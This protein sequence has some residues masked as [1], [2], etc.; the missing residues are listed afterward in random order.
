[1]LVVPVTRRLPGAPG[2]PG[3]GPGPPPPEQEK[4]EAEKAEGSTASLGTVSVTAQ[5]RTENLQ[6]VPISMLVLG[7]QQLEEMNVT[8][9]D[10]YAKLLPSVSLDRGEGGGSV[11]YMRGVA[12]GENSN[13]S[14][15][16][17]SVGVYLDEQSVTTIGGILD[18]AKVRDAASCGADGICIVRG[19]GDEPGSVV[20]AMQAAMRAG[21]ADAASSA[22]HAAWP[23]P[24]L[25]SA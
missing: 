7:D 25:A 8:D 20:P 18:A 13:H 12:S 22:S 6:K 3:P 23:H 14:G 5:K 11:P 17:P 15:P 19:L 2:T 24:S 4:K 1:M 21:R 10:D 16:Q 9:F